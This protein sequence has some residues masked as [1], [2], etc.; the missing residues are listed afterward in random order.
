MIE[1]VFE[2]KRHTFFLTLY[3]FYFSKFQNIFLNVPETAV[4]LIRLTHE[5]VIKKLM[6]PEHM[7]GDE[8]KRFQ[9]IKTSATQLLCDDSIDNRVS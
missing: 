3:A 1:N 8:K 4:Y 5:A 7:V 2:K 6:W 9:D